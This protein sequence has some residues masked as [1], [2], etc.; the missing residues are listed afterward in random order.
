MMLPNLR[1]LVSIMITYDSQPECTIDL[2]N[3]E[4]DTITQW[5]YLCP[6]LEICHMPSKLNSVLIICVGA[7]NSPG[8]LGW[9]RLRGAESVWIPTPGTGAI[10]SPACVVWMVNRYRSGDASN[11]FNILLGRIYKLHMEGSLDF[12][13]YDDVQGLENLGTKFLCFGVQLLM[14]TWSGMAKFC[15]LP[16]FHVE[17]VI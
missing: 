15:N 10:N 2:M 3:D 12:S 13:S 7:D 14:I 4:Y 9:R 1:K 17:G 5:G 8:R 6:S 16:I 11:P